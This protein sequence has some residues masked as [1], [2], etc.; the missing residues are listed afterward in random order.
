MTEL[1][2]NVLNASFHGSIVILAVLLLRFLL[3]K[4]PK[5]FLCLLWLLAGI[6]LLMPFEIRSDF[7]LQ[8]DVESFRDVQ[9]A[10]DIPEP[11]MHAP[12]YVEE[13]VSLTPDFGQQMDVP[14]QSEGMLSSESVIGAYRPDEVPEQENVL[15]T[16]DKVAANIWLTIAFGFGLYTMASYIRLRLQVREAIRLQGNVWE[17]DR[18]ETAFI[19]GFIRP[20]IYL[21]MGMSESNR[22]HILA[23]ERTHLEKGDHWIKMIGFLALAIHWFNPLVWLAYILLCKDIEMAC[24]ERVVQ[25]MELEERKSYSAALINCSTNRAHFGACPVAF[26]EVS[27]KNRVLTV[28]NYKKPSFWISLA[29]VIAIIFVAVCLVTSPA[30][31]T[32]AIT[33]ETTE[34]TLPPREVVKVSTVDELLSAIGPDREIVLETGSYNLGEASAYGQNSHSEYYTWG[35]VYD[36]YELILTNVENLAIRGSGMHV[37]LLETDPRYADVIALE[38]CTN[39]E[40]ADF[41]AGHTRDRGECS[42]GVISLRR[43]ND[44]DLHGMGLYGC[45]VIGLETEACTGI[46]LTDSDIY[47]CSSSALSLNGTQDVAVSGCRIYSIGEEQNGGYS[48]FTAWDSRNICIENNEIS[49][50]EVCHLLSTNTSGITLK[51]NR[52]SGNRFTRGVMDIQYDGLDQRPADNGLNVTL[53][54]NK[55]EGNSI[56]KWFEY[57][58]V[59][60]YDGKGQVWTEEALTKEYGIDP[61]KQSQTQQPQLQIHVSTV[62]EL[63]AAIGPDKEI[64]LD[65][66]MYD[67]STATGYGTSRG[68]YYY[69]EDIFDGPGLVIQNVNNMTIRSDDGDVN[70]H[71]IAAIP[72]YADVLAFKSCSNITVSGFTAGHTKEQGSCAGGVL[73]FRDSDFITVDNCGLFGCGILGIQTEG[74][75]NVTVQN[76]EIYECSN[77]GI[78]MRDTIQVSL[79]NNTFRDIGGSNIM[80]FHSCKDVQIDGD[81]VIGDNFSSY[82]ISTPEQQE[83]QK[84]RET[85]YNFVYYYRTADTINLKPLLADS[86]TGDVT[87]RIG[88]DLLDTDVPEITGA[89]LEG[90]KED[91]MRL[92]SVTMRKWN[93]GVSDWEEGEWKLNYTVIEE[94]GEFRVKDYSLR[95]LY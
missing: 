85:V 83:L 48:L 82:S 13:D 89:D 70:K 57:F 52:I 87:V 41:T 55:L 78:D 56:R 47:D 9:I 71:T 64:I 46:T 18:I 45:G 43:S 37:T 30:E 66:K 88:D 62:D 24:D 81:A 92:F 33:P 73:E 63:I 25:F 94:D 36:G 86:Y 60:I 93:P 17:C 74:C 22:N 40:L 67:L 61:E 21:P 69:W 38:N 75:S 95:Q 77:G 20:R 26:G 35:Q 31:E 28:L 49:D 53:D 51:N 5:K 91:G 54:N 39:V 23:H 79:E 15:L 6:R 12:M 14:Y 11:T 7:S 65:A 1:F 32:A 76:C 50:S 59:D 8:P 16:L 90:I 68:E 42:G 84:L 3:K 19:L 44:I 4:T 72:R 2:Q 80:S 58:A 29:G 10:E 34:E 27:V